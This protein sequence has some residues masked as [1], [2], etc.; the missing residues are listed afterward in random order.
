MC[1]NIYIP[2]DAKQISV[3]VVIGNAKAVTYMLC[4]FAPQPAGLY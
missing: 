4:A 2:G 1:A 3:G